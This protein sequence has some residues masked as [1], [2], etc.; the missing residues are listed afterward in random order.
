MLAITFKIKF[1]QVLGGEE[2]D[3][4][5]VDFLSHISLIFLPTNL[6]R[7]SFSLPSSSDDMGTADPF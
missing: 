3:G 2:V 4:S 7:S 5:I 6:R 1:N